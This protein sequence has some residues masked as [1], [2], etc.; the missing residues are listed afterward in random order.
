MI[1][2]F[3]RVHPFQPTQ[4]FLSKRLTYSVYE[5]TAPKLSEEKEWYHRF[6][7]NEI[8]AMLPKNPAKEEEKFI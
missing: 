4:P 6:A 7:I 2:N 3:I 1:F 5:S 8:H